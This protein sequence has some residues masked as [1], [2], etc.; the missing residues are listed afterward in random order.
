MLFIRS[1]ARMKF[2]MLNIWWMWSWVS[3][4][5]MPVRS[6]SFSTQRKICGHVEGLNESAVYSGSTFFLSILAVSTL[7]HNTIQ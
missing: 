3:M 5:A 1:A 7:K 4:K 6:L 2:L